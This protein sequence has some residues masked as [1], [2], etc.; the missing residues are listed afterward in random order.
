[1]GRRPASLARAV[2]PEPEAGH[3][4]PMQASEDLFP[5]SGGTVEVAGEGTS[6]AACSSAPLARPP[7][8]RPA[9]SLLLTLEEALR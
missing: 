3:P 1:M 2:A 5:R 6:G 9:E 8:Q 4:P 7:R